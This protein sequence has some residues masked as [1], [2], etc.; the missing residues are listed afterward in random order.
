MTFNLAGRFINIA[1]Y[2]IYSGHCKEKKD[3]KEMKQKGSF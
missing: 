2:F 1:H 3:Y